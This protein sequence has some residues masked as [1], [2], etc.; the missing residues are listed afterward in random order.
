MQLDLYDDY[1]SLEYGFG[2][3]YIV[4]RSYVPQ[5]SDDL[6]L[7]EGDTVALLEDLKNG[8]W[9]GMKLGNEEEV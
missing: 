2:V 1:D 5:D 9:R 6:E 4:I 8:W 3:D 7:K